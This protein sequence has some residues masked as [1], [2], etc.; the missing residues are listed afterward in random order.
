MSSASTTRIAIGSV[1]VVLLLGMCLSRTQPAERARSDVPRVLSQ[2]APERLTARAASRTDEKADPPAPMTAP[3]EDEPTVAILLRDLADGSPVVGIA[4][5][6][7]DRRR[8]APLRS[9]STDQAG[10]AEVPRSWT[11]KLSTSVAGW[12]V[13]VDPSD[14][15][16]PWAWRTMRVLGEVVDPNGLDVSGVDIESMCIAP[17]GPGAFSRKADRTP[18]WT[19]ADLHRMHVP[20]RFTGGRTDGSGQFA[21]DV[22]RIRGVRVLAA[23]A[24]GRWGLADVPVHAGL[25]EQRVRIELQRGSRVR[26]RLLGS[27]GRPLAGAQVS[28]AVETSVQVPD[29]DVSALGARNEALSIAGGSEPGD[30]ARVWMTRSATTDAS[31]NFDVVVRS[32]GRCL[33]SAWPPGHVPVEARPTE[34]SQD[35]GDVHAQAPETSGRLA[36]V[37]ESEPLTGHEIMLVDLS[38]GIGQPV[39]PRTTLDAHGAMAAD[40]LVR[41]RLYYVHVSGKLA[42]EQGM[43]GVFT[44]DGQARIDA[45]ALRESE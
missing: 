23:A 24:D 10:V 27:D 32:E 17:M 16:R 12:V 4:L 11:R 20:R 8:D 9:I 28:L 35:L 21:I 33:V 45:S 40:W 29:I 6:P 2:D 22:P 36:F 15:A 31:G 14:P 34:S 5:E 38:A 19:D 42:G 3:G 43:S 18:P 25:D 13:H 1:F 44:W 7:S 26:G 37:R 41:G 30:H 39:A